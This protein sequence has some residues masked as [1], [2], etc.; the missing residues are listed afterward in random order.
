MSVVPAGMT[1]A[2]FKQAQAQKIF[3]WQSEVGL[4]R[5]EGM[6]TKVCSR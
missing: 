4:E 6:R 3:Y 2:F 5:K 1:D